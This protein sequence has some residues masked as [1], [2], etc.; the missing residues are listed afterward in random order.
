[1]AD[2]THLFIDGEYLRQVHHEAMRDCFGTDGELDIHE[3]KRE[4]SARF[5]TIRLTKPHGQGKRKRPA[6]HV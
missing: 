1:M 4:Q 6:A 3:A 2:D 5:F